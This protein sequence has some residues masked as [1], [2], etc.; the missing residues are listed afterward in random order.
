MLG[1][2]IVPTSEAR[3][4]IASGEAGCDDRHGPRGMALRDITRAAAL[5][6]LLACGMTLV[7]VGLLGIWGRSAPLT[8]P[9][10]PTPADIWGRWSFDPLVLIGL[11]LGAWLYLRGVGRLWR[12]AGPGRGVRGWQVACASPVAP[13]ISPGASARLQSGPLRRN[14]QPAVPF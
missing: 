3:L 10:P 5:V 11:A 6:V 9:P 12:R 14:A 13:R 1:P 7:A 8:P 4:I 2:G